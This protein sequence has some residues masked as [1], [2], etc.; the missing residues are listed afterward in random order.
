MIEGTLFSVDFGWS[1]HHKLVALGNDSK[2][3]CQTL[4]LTNSCMLFRIWR[5]AWNL[6]LRVFHSLL[7]RTSAAFGQESKLMMAEY[8]VLR[9]AQRFD[10]ERGSLLL[11]AYSRK[12]FV[13][14]RILVQKLRA[15]PFARK[16][17]QMAHASTR[18]MHCQRVLHLIG[19]L[20]FL[21]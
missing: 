18:V 8:R 13:S 6:Y 9:Q 16:L 2:E 17:T 4:L 5:N 21:E 12:K 11:F 3:L 20:Y 1:S 7:E 15:K 14:A 10:G 19:L